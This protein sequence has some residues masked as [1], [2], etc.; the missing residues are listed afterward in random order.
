M[1]NDRTQPMELAQA[2]T[3]STR[4]GSLHP[5]RKYA[6]ARPMPTFECLVLPGND[7]VGMRRHELCLIVNAGALNPGFNVRNIE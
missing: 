5:R 3:S 4:A 1:M 7:P 2:F 6:G